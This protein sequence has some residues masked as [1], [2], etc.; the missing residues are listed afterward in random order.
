MG[1]NNRQKSKREERRVLRTLKRNSLMKQAA[2]VS[3]SRE[4]AE[5]RLKTLDEKYKNEEPSTVN[6]LA[7]E[8][9]E[10]QPQAEE[11]Q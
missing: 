10:E 6:K 11:Q 3:L 4:E 5:A 1:M 9:R 8:V 7:E 2:K